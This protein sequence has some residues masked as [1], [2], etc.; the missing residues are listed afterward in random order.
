MGSSSERSSAPESQLISRRTLVRAGATAAWTVPLVQVV[1]AA[2]ALAA[3]S[4]TK[5]NLTATLTANYATGP[6]VHV[7]GT[8]NTSGASATALQ[9]TIQLPT[10]VT[11]SDATVAPGNNWTKPS[12]F[13]G[14]T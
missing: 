4:T 1:S 14:N 2:P 3:V 6:K 12:S 10:G 11:A 7:S 13:G 8:V 9:L 5:S